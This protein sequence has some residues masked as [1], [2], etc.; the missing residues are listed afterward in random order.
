MVEV[1]GF[2][3]S[4]RALLFGAASAALSCRNKPAGF[5]GYCFV[6]NRDGNSVA[7]VDL[8]RLRRVRSIPLPAAPSQILALP[9]LATPVAASSKTFILTPDTGTVHEL[10]AG[11]LALSRHAQAGKSA[12][13]MALAPS[14]DSLWVLL[15]DPQQFVEIPLDSFQPRRRI[16]LD[17]PADSFDISPQGQAAIA[18]T[19]A[20]TITLV[21]LTTGAIDRIIAA[22]DAPSVICFQRDGRQL[23]AGSYAS[24]NLAIFDTAAGQT[25]VRMPLAIAPRNFCTKSDGGEIYVSG[26]GMDAVAIV[27]PYQTEVAETVLAGRGPGAMTFAG[28][29][30]LVANPEIGRVTALDVSL[31]R[32]FVTVVDVGQ[33][34]SRL[35][36]TPD[37]KWAF[38]L[39]R[40]SGDMAVIL[41][42]SL[43]V[44][45][46]HLEPSHV[47]TILPVGET[48]IDAAIVSRA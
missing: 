19:A 41:L 21:T 12:V 11:S 38:T 48:P 1:P 40:Q 6:A 25:V 23:L 18:S 35:F 34:P 24:R 3:V 7:V 47:F 29:L 32:K 31:S 14:N 13:A 39:N 4:R 36:A 16:N 46:P 44:R 15:R 22:E 26:D 17:A 9:P 37:E 45:R 8:Q 42:A 33:Q 30:L 2:A 5:S 27:Y 10:D 20:R 43:T 28:G